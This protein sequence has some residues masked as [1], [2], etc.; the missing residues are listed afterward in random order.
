MVKKLVGKVTHFYPNICVAVVKVSSALKVGDKISIE[1]DNDKIEQTVKSMQIEH[2]QIK[3]AKKG[4]EIGMKVEG[5]V[6]HGAK[7]YKA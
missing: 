6:K 4:Q 7:V 5:E 1:K 3:E 2:E